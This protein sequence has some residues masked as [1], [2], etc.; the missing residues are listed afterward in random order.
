MNY[1][2]PGEIS[3]PTT[4]G[5][6]MAVVAKEQCGEWAKMAAAELGVDFPEEYLA[7]GRVLAFLDPQQTI[8][9]G[10]MIVVE[11]PFR[12]LQSIGAEGDA[13]DDIDLDVGSLAEINGV[14]ISPQARTTLA[15]MQFWRL[16][17]KEAVAT[18]R[19]QFLFTYPG[20]NGRLPA[21][22][23]LVKP[24]ILYSGVTR[25]LPGMKQQVAETIAVIEA[26]RIARLLA[27]LD[28]GAAAS[29]ISSMSGFLALG[30]V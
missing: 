2:L 16:L 26:K 28:A 4:R 6:Q 22:Y 20:N 17:L 1:R 24:R 15:S 3:A 30:D 25:L 14:W 19:E 9:G 5:H 12:S 13:R 21:A 7:R 23:L 11:P 8:C 27:M 29:P 18:G 10:A